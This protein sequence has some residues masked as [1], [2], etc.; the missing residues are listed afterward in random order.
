[1][2][3][4]SDHENVPTLSYIHLFSEKVESESF[5]FLPFF[6][7]FE[8]CLRQTPDRRKMGTMEGKVLLLLL[9]LLLLLV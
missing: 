1:M 4:Y 2:F 9:L 6:M 7:I 8:N 3:R 5:K